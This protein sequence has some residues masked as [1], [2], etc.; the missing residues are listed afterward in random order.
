MKILLTALNLGKSTNQTAQPVVTGKIIKPK[1][2]AIP[3]IEEQQR[4]VDKLEKMLPLV[5]ALAQMD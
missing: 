3:P 1:V 4:I 5:D 2:I